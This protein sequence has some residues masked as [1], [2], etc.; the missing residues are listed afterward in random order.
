M[1]MDWNY[2][3]YFQISTTCR[4]ADSLRAIKN[5]MWHKGKLDGIGHSINFC[6]FQNFLQ[7][8]LI[9]EQ[10]SLKKFFDKQF[11]GSWVSLGYGMSDG[12]KV[13]RRWGYFTWDQ[14]RTVYGFWNGM[15]EVEGRRAGE[16]GK[17]WFSVCALRQLFWNL[18]FNK[19]TKIRT[20]HM[21]GF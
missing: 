10:Q 19:A 13:P 21:T 9:L 1:C 11:V 8:V 4:V 3:H 18:S 7:Y 17:L 6:P 20:C 14:G 15:C 16:W 12:I 5:E 2:L